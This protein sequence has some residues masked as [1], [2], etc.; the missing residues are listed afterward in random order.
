MNECCCF[1]ATVA[2]FEYCRIRKT[3]SKKEGMLPFCEQ[4]TPL[5]KIFNLTY[6]P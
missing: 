1:I 5:Y 2:V 4:H 3:D 6:S